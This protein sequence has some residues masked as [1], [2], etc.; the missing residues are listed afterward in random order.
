MHMPTTTRPVQLAAGLVLSLALAACS[1]STGPDDDHHEPAGLRATLG[2]QV[3]VSVNP[4]R[5][6]TGSFSV[7]AGITSGPITVEFLDE[8]GDVIAVDD[9]EYLGVEVDTPARLT[10]TQNPAGSFTIQL[11]GVTAGTT[12]IRLKLMHGVPPGGHADYISPNIG[13]TV[14]P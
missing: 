12:N 14:T 11:V 5:Q 1:D 9:E 2:G 4:A 3:V 10:I 6:V 7:A 13:V 8:D